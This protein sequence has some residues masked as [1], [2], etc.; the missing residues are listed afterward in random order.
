MGLVGLKSDL[1]H[2]RTFVYKCSVVIFSLYVTKL[3]AADFKRDRHMNL[4]QN[5]KIPWGP[6]R[7]RLAEIESTFL[8]S[9]LSLCE[10]ENSSN[11]VLSPHSGLL[12]GSSANGG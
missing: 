7:N 11:L 5:I 10:P 2:I 9:D 4:H 8:P 12:R 3:K 1:T 6:S